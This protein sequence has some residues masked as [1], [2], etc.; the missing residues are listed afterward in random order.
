MK[1]LLIFICLF[2]CAGWMEIHPVS[3]G[4]IRSDT[5]RVRV[6]GEAREEGEYELPL[7][8]T[9]DDLIALCGV[10]D[11]GD[12]NALN[13]DTVLKDHDVLHIP[14]AETENGQHKVSI[15]SGTAEELCTL[16]GIGES[17]A[18]K[19]ISWREEHG[20]FQTLDDLKQVSGIGDAKFEKIAGYIML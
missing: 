7:Y 9:V 14:E 20:L 2:L 1:P 16:P 3:A 12:L 17:T 11:Q 19:I 18:A 6:T 8:S 13:P 5:I 10:T 15:N 4:R